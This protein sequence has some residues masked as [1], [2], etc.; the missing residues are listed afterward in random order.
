MGSVFFLI[1]NKF[2]V[3]ILYILQHSFAHCDVSP[4]PSSGSVTPRKKYINKKLS[5]LA[6]TCIS[7]AVAPLPA[8]KRHLCFV[9]TRGRQS[10][11]YIY[12]M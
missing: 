6:Q 10:S 3:E 4:A 8:L 2:N 7:A 1:E 5:F 9:D 12:C 11:A